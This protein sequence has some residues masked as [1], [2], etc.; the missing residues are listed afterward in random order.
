VA[1]AVSGTG[2]GTTEFFAETLQQLL[3]S[4]SNA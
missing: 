4:T 3:P 2:K 1:F